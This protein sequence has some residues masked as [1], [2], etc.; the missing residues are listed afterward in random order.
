MTKYF[1]WTAILLGGCCIMAVTALPPIRIQLGPDQNIC[2]ITEPEIRLNPNSKKK[3]GLIIWLHGGMRSSNHEKGAEAHRAILPFIDANKYY[4]ASPSAFGGQDWLTPQG[5]AHIDTLIHYM[6][7]HY[8]IDPADINMV[9]VSDGTLGTIAY[10]LNGHYSLHRRIL[11]SCFPQIVLPMEQ[12]QSPGLASLKT[13]S[14]DFFQGGHDRLFP[15]DQ[16]LPFLQT[17]EKNYPNVH[18]HYFPEGEHDFSFYAEYAQAELKKLLI[19]VTKASKKIVK[20]FR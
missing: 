6:L 10:S 17:W 20:V 13:G 5:L 8:P 7:G 9:G 15:I 1:S 4:L 11:I 16:V 14:W 2:G 12:I 19:P 3:L 18:V